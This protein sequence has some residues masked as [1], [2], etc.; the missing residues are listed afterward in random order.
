[1]PHPLLKPDTNGVPWVSP[2]SKSM[3]I[4]EIRRASQCRNSCVC[5]RE[6]EKLRSLIANMHVEDR[7]DDL[8]VEICPQSVS[9]DVDVV[10][11]DLGD[12]SEN[13]ADPDNTSEA[14]DERRKSKASLTSSVN[15]DNSGE[16]ESTAV[17]LDSRNTP[18]A[19]HAGRS[20]RVTKV[21][22]ATS[23]KQ[24]EEDLSLSMESMMSFID[25]EDAKSQHW[26]RQIQKTRTYQCLSI[27]ALI[28]ALF[29]NSIVVMADFPDDPATAILVAS[30]GA[31]LALFSSDMVLNLVVEFRDYIRS[32]F[33]LLDL[34]GTVSIALDIFLLSGSAVSLG[35]DMSLAR[36]ARA[37][38][39]GAKAGRMMKLLRVISLYFKTYFVEEGVNLMRNKLEAKVIGGQLVNELSTKVA[40]LSTVLVLGGP[41]F[42][43][44]LY[45]S[46]DLSMLSWTGRLEVDFHH[47]KEVLK[48]SPHQNTTDIFGIS[49]ASFSEFYDD[50]DY[51]PF[52]LQGWCEEAII[53]GRSVTIPG[54]ELLQKRS[55]NRRDNVLKIELQ[56]D[57]LL[58][59]SSSSG[60]KRSKAVLFDFTEPNRMESIMDVAMLMFA[61]AAMVGSASGIT[62]V[63]DR[64]LVQPFS[65]MLSPV[66]IILEAYEIDVESV[67]SNELEVVAYVLDRLV[68]L[69]TLEDETKTISA[70]EFQNLDE[71]SKAVLTQLMD[72]S[73]ENT[74]SDAKDDL[75]LDKIPP[76]SSKTKVDLDLINSWH[77][78]VLREDNSSLWQTVLYI[79]FD[80]DLGKRTSHS[81]TNPETFSSFH[82][83][84]LRQYNELPYH[85]YQ[86]AIDV[87]HV[88]YRFQSLLETKRWLTRIEQY[89]LLVAALGHD[90][91][92]FGR[93]NPFLME[94]RDDLALQYND[95]SPLEMMHCARLFR[96]I[97]REGCGIFEK[98]SK[99]EYNLGR[100]VCIE[101]ILHTDNVHHFHS[102][103]TVQ[104]LYE[105]QCDIIEVQAYK[106]ALETK[107]LE[108]V[109]KRHKSTWI[110][111]FLHM[112]DISNPLR[113]YSIC[114]AWAHRILDEFF[115]QGDEE[116]KLGVPVGM[117]NDREKVNRLGSQHGFINFMVAPFAV[118][119]VKVFPQLNA[120]TSQ[121]VAN[122]GHW[123]NAWIQDSKPSVE[124]V[125]K[126]EHDIEKLSQVA[127]DLQ[128]RRQPPSQKDKRRAHTSHTSPAP[129]RRFHSRFSQS[130]TGR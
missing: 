41:I 111:T 59:D 122:M 45:P 47:A 67:C 48:F 55:P 44:P 99:E 7:S 14:S 97:S 100:N 54:Q 72:Y 89:A 129:R 79:F 83:A 18:S 53:D 66:L 84:V 69:R 115:E 77:Y 102:L 9:H 107:Y 123:L 103:K 80:S 117:L 4:E 8:K 78:D 36:S 90:L 85:N 112:A 116:K 37:A 70:E 63:V 49:V 35:V 21:F 23:Q 75:A 113:P 76:A 94:T 10:L 56:K 31:C 52:S 81:W 98:A 26:A 120:L 128:A 114:S 39:I 82:N 22:S 96:I 91:G 68:R 30:L 95:K 106:S 86:H 108:E 50:L 11:G 127:E 46:E 65:A 6:V 13:A 119:V 33:F 43:I 74:E 28:V 3:S 57:Q 121:V 109:L 104:K 51:K 16:P 60:C 15:T 58:T 73:L 101:A 20:P 88:I 64:V 5:C 32:P 71:D 38:K 24:E 87:L 40:V 105:A 61:L 17:P 62:Q 124:D 42:T 125:A 1:M 92:H 12:I 2:S 27:T 110:P 93:T 29:A 126:R 25:P 118:G 130:S 19:E 34:L